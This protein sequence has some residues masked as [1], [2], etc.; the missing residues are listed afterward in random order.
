M[1]INYGQNVSIS[2]MAGAVSIAGSQGGLWA[3]V[4]G[5]WQLADGLIR[6]TNASLSLNHKVVSVTAVEEKYELAFEQGTATCDVV[7]MATPLDESKITFIPSVNLLKRH[8]QH[9]YTTFVRGL[10][11][12]VQSSNPY[13]V[14]RTIFWSSSA[15]KQSNIHVW[16]FMPSV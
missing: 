8:M 7:V 2:G 5:N 15:W 1:R 9:T 13:A 12:P 16:V 4:G 10:L 6:H 11:N 14:R 3:V